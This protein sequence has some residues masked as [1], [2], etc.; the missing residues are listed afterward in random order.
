M[1]ELL[2]DLGLKSSS[3]IHEA[4]QYHQKKREKDGALDI[5]GKHKIAWH[6]QKI[7][8][9]IRMGKEDAKKGHRSENLSY[10]DPC[11]SKVR[12]MS[13]CGKC[14]QKDHTARVCIMPALEK[15]PRVQLVRWYKEYNPQVLELARKQIRKTAQPKLFDW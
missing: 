3:V 4:M 10:K 1:V 12:E 8:K 5:T 14:K 2:D 13:A 7:F 9:N 6:Q 15:R 11:K